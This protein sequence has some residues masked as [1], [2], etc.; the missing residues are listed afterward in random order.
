MAQVANRLTKCVSLV[1]YATDLPPTR[2]SGC[3]SIR[4]DGRRKAPG[5][6]PSSTVARSA[7]DSH[8]RST[9]TGLSRV[10]SRTAGPNI[11][12]ARMSGGAG[13][14]EMELSHSRHPFFVM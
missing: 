8:E 4:C 14:V 12:L 3:S 11:V 1:C 5:A 2:A 7:S 6:L 9:S 13:W 10:R